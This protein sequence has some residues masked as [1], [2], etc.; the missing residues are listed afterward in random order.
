MTERRIVIVG[1]GIT[2]LAAAHAALARARELGTDVAVTVLERSPRFGGNLVTEQVDGFLLDGGP[3][4]WVASKPEASALARDL[5]LG[6]EL[7]GTNEA[8]RRYYIERGGRLHAVPE[9]FILGVPTRLL[10]VVRTGLFSWRGKLRMA[11]EPFVPARHFQADD[12][13]SIADFCKRRLGSEATERLVAPLLAGITSGD[14]SEASMCATF[15]QMVAME[16]EYG[17]LVRGMWALARRRKK[18]ESSSAFVSLRGGTGALVGALVER[19]RTDGVAMR[20]GAGARSV[21]REG[22]GWTVHLDSG[23]AITADAL[24]LAVPAPV[25]SRLLVALDGDLARG[26]ASIPYG[27]SATVFLAYRRSDVAHPLDGVGFLVPRAP[28]RAIRAGTWVSS[29]CHGR[30]PEGHV[31]LRAFLAGDSLAL[32]DAGLAA[33]ARREL[34]VLMNLEAEPLWSRVFRFEE[35]RAQMR[36][37]HL[38]KVRAI[39]ERLA[40]AA[41]GLRFAAGGF[42]GDSIPDSVRQGQEAGRAMVEGELSAYPGRNLAEN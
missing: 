42:D 30:A 14:A 18:G 36:V 16:R 13:E 5:G 9:G 19:L 20:A 22:A 40:T 28:G 25:A 39:R 38:A 3:D 15:P 11:I 17:S 2:G 26:L 33:L 27:S 8:T 4:S 32:D 10:P 7:I 21:A 23:G 41:S 1:G 31:L 24:L 37:G 35:A 6:P 12:D 34:G 29:K